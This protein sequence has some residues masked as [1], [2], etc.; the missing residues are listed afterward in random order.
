MSYGK[1][2]IPMEFFI[3][4]D[5]HNLQHILNMINEWWREG[6]FPED[7]L[8][9]MIAS[10]YK[11]GD[12]KKQENYRP[13][14]LLCSVYKIYA[15]LLQVR[16]SKAIDK[17]IYKTQYGFRKSRSTTIP[18]ACVRRILER[19][20]ATQ[21]PIYLVFLDWE[22]AF[23]RVK[24]DKLL[25]SLERMGFPV[26]YIAAIRS[27]Y[28]NPSFAVKIGQ[29]ESSW[30][31]QSRGIRQGCPL[32]PYLFIIL[33]TVMFRDIHSELNMSRGR[34][35]GIDYTDLLYADDTALI[36]SNANAMNRLVAKIEEHAHYYGLNFNRGKCVSMNFHGI[37]KPKFPNGENI[38]EVNETVYLG[39]VIS[40]EHDVKKEVQA[41]IASCFAVLNKLNAFW[42]KSSCPK[43]FNLDVFDAV[44][45][46]KL[47]YGLEVVQL[48]DSI[49]KKL[50]VFQ[51]KGLRK[52][53]GMQTTFVNRANTNRKVVENA[54]AIRNPNCVP[55]KDI[56]LFS[57]YVADRQEALIKHTIRETNSDPLRQ[58]TFEPDSA[59][60]VTM[61]NRRVGRPREKWAYSNLERMHIK[62]GFGTKQDF[63]SHLADSCLNLEALARNRTI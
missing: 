8:R 55:G 20:E 44:I 19:A 21:D 27:F 28:S 45:R 60:P 14:S 36:T 57:S 50:D 40:K 17:D 63:K 51:L 1:A 32:S 41:K 5:E 4:L 9:A 31:K 18:L 46:S 61:Q 23:D 2:M 12:P 47:V 25:E 62:Y 37:R 15:S 58:C 7:K 52:I 35:Q 13:I 24:Q 3:W 33:M 42:F 56:K 43:K 29:S 11:K 48:P 49:L 59:L 54:N 38:M 26:K 39:G 10:I 34:V 53:L 22:K 6:F 30:K 16:I